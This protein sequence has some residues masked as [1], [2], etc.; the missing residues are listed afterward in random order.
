MKKLNTGPKL[1]SNE[2]YEQNIKKK[3]RKDSNTLYEYSLDSPNPPPNT[4]NNTKH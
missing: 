1:F 4:H 2:K 3:L